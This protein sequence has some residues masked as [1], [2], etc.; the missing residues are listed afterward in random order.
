[1]WGPA[2]P[3][4]STPI[5]LGSLWAILVRNWSKK[6]P[7][8]ASRSPREWIERCERLVGDQILVYKR[9]SIDKEDQSD[10]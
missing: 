10:E 9:C 2:V 1:V 6:P 3:K 5:G 8:Q 7:T 4:T